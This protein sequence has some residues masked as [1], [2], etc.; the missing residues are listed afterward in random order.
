MVGL[1]TVFF[2]RVLQSQTPIESMD[3]HTEKAG[4]EPKAVTGGT[5]AENR[6]DA[7]TAG[8]E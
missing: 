4:I 2:C 7:W 6:Q 8:C 3:S 5:Y 1:S